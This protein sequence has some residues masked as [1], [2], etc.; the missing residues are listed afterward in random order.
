MTQSGITNPTIASSPARPAAGGPP[1]PRL[2]APTIDPVRV[3]RQNAWRIAGVLAVGA[4]LGVGLNFLFG[5]F[6]P[7]WSSQVLFEIRNQLE[8]ANDLTAKDIGT[9]DTVIRLATRGRRCGR[10]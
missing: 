7:L 10:S 2:S 5:R 4:V 6:Y 8:D 9:E 1:R 3:L